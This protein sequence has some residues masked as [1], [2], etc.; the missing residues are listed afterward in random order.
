MISLTQPARTRSSVMSKGSAGAVPTLRDEVAAALERLSR[1]MASQPSPTVEEA[2][3]FLGQVV[4]SWDDVTEHAFPAR[5]AGFGSVV[6]V[7][8][9]GSGGQD[10]FVLMAGPL[11]DF[12][13]GQVSLASP[14]GHALLGCSVGDVVTV[15]T[16]QRLRT[17]RV[18]AVRT[19]QDRL[20][21]QHSVAAA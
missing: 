20:T 9:L 7:E 3:R 15:Q 2:V 13:A 1:T 19:L 14:I 5:G 18:L 17:L 21:E 11:L 8:D 16:P 12:D 6:Q 10:T 4:A